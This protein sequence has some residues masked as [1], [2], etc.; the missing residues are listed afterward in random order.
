MKVG[1][2][3]KKWIKVFR[4]ITSIYG[5]LPAANGRKEEETVLSGKHRIDYWWVGHF[6][7]VMT[8]FLCPVVL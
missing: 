5:G 6:L 8:A 1:G 4:P 3:I 2:L 7:V